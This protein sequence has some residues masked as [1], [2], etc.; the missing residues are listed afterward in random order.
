MAEIAID[1][2]FTME[3]FMLVGTL[4]PS[5][6]TVVPIFG[7]SFE[8]N[9]RARVLMTVGSGQEVTDAIIKKE[10]AQAYLSVTRLYRGTPT[11]LTEGPI[12]T[13]NKDLAYLQGKLVGTPFYRGSW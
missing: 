7:Q 10:Q 12:L 3:T 5:R 8:T 1:G 6:H 9:W 4:R 11:Q 13:F 2:S